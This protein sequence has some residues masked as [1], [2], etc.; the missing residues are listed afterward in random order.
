MSRQLEQELES[1]ARRKQIRLAHAV[2]FGLERAVQ[3]KGR[4]FYGL[5][6]RHRPADALI[7]LKST[8]GGVREVAFVGAVSLSE[9]LLK[10]V[11][12]AE[13]GKLGWREDKF[14]G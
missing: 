6:F 5:T 2:D 12:L 8:V 10:A 7:V 3:Q 14:T 9:A 1:T 13:A 11:R 4:L